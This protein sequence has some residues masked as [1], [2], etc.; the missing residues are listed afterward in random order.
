M[1]GVWVNLLPHRDPRGDI[2]NGVVTTERFDLPTGIAVYIPG[3]R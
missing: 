3:M 2:P 1:K